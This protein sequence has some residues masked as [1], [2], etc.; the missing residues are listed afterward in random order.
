MAAVRVAV[1]ELDATVGRV[2]HRVVDP[3]LH[4][5]GAHRHRRVGDPFRQREDV[6]HH[7]E[8][9]G[10]ERRAQPAESRDHF[11]EDQQ[12]AVLRAD[13]AQL[14]QVA[15]GRNEHAGRPGHRF[16]D[17]RRNRLGA[18]LGHNLLQRVGQV[19]APGRLSF[20]KGVL[21]QV[22]RVRQVIHLR[23]QLRRKRLLVRLDAADRDATEAHAVVA[24]QPAHEAR[25]LRFAARL[26]VGQ[27]DLQR[28][29][30][31]LGPR[32]REEH[33]VDARGQDPLQL[34]RELEARRVPHLEARRKVERRSRFGDRVDDRLPA[35][36]GIHAPQSR[37]AVENLAPVIG[38]VV[39]VLGAHQ[40]A[41]P[42]LERLVGGEWHPQRFK[43]RIMG[44]R[45]S[46]HGRGTCQAHPAG[47]TP[48]PAPAFTLPQPCAFT[49]PLPSPCLCPCLHPAPAPA[50]T[51]PLPLPSLCPCPCRRILTSAS[52]SRNANSRPR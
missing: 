7:V 9:L 16:H 10:G 17:H 47:A 28:A 43:R 19:S 20:G 8:R 52:R 4:A 32:V 14:L 2:H 38:P 21:R 33:M 13:R 1:E 24:A 41:R 45:G 48:L 49:Q 51:L 15:H 23:Q 42:R 29:V 34:V 18:P 37:G 6:R 39:H 26:M 40:Q 5:G 50:F 3:P 44:N 31:G 35:M 25:A 27:R 11:I 36:P 30:H 12:D 46:S 22:V